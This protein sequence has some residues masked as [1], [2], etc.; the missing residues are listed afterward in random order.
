MG[1]ISSM[2]A[3][4]IPSRDVLWTIPQ[5]F[6]SSL[7]QGSMVESPTLGTHIPCGILRA[8]NESP[9]LLSLD[10]NKY[11][12]PKFQS[13]HKSF[14]FVFWQECLWVSQDKLSYQQQ[15]TPRAKTTEVNLGRCCMCI[16]KWF[17]QGLCS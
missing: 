4:I 7:L 11:Y 15:M 3:I 9:V 5:F 8:I 10:S 13:L 6:Q 17:L 16:G 2:V 1:G 14:K 12:S